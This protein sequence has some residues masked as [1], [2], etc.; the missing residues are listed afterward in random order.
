MVALASVDDPEMG[1]NLVDLGVVGEVEVDDGRVRVSLI[2][3]SATCPMA[4]LM[5]EDARRAVQQAC[6][7][8]TEVDVYIDWDTKWSPERLAPALRERFGW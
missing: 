8:G 7:I 4:D 2:P 6:P 3:T 5:V 1:E